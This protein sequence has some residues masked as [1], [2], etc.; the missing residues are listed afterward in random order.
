MIL[1]IDNYDSFV[2][3]V[4]RYIERAGAHVEI[5]R[6]DCLT[7]D[8]IAAGPPQAIVISPGPGRPAEAGISTE[9]VRAFSGRIPLLGVC[10]GHQCIGEAFGGNVTRARRPLH[11]IASKIDHDGSALFQGLP[12]PLAVGRYHSLIVAENEAMTETLM[13]AARSEEGEVMA[14]RHQHHPT[15]GVQFHPESILT[16]GGNRLFENFLSLVARWRNQPAIS[17]FAAG[18]DDARN[19]SSKA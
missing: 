8:L 11:G 17:D 6:N 3:N 4:G 12:R 9:V 7:L 2:F 16:E 15:Y 19:V 10:L 1:L 13:V 18:R 5:V 14:L